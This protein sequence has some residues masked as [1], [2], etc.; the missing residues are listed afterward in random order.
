MRSI[1]LVLILVQG[2]NTGADNECLPSACTS[3]MLARLIPRLRLLGGS[4]FDDSRPFSFKDLR[5]RRRTLPDALTE[6]KAMKMEDEDHD[7]MDPI[8]MS[9]KLRDMIRHYQYDD[10][11]KMCS[12]IIG[13]DPEIKDT[14]VTKAKLLMD[15]L[16]DAQAAQECLHGALNFSRNNVDA[17]SLL[18]AISNDTAVASRNLSRAVAIYP[19][20]ASSLRYHG[21]LMLENDTRKGHE[22][23]VKAR[24]NAPHEAEPE[25]SLAYSF[26]RQGMLMKAREC[27]KTV[28]MQTASA[29]PAALVAAERADAY[30][31]KKS[32]NVEDAQATLHACFNRVNQ[33]EQEDEWVRAAK[34]SKA[35]QREWS[36][37]VS[38]YAMIVNVTHGTQAAL[39]Y[40]RSALGLLP[41]SC[42]VRGIVCVCLCVFVCLCVCVCVCAC[43]RAIA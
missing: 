19:Y 30:L 26:V 9:Q 20:H 18:G 12:M 28:K 3:T 11:L 8:E 25:L 1:F 23:I 21:L 10:A 34:M 7:N 13:I 16:G 37:A 17:L 4:S 39:G 42:Q 15:Y 36:L 2:W 32:G 40:V 33:S 29:C 6:I 22:M 38:E 43:V 41:K 31:L 27:I 24:T 14:W 5:K 35:M